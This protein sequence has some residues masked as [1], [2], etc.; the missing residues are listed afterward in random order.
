MSWFFFFLLFFGLFS[1]WLLWFGLWINLSL[2]FGLLASFLS[3]FHFWDD[4]FSLS[5]NFIHL[6]FN[7]HSFSDL[8]NGTVNHINETFKRVLVEGVNFRKIGEEEINEG[9]S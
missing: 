6:L 2:G 8:I 9:A 7:L 3:W 5:V 1:F 4:S